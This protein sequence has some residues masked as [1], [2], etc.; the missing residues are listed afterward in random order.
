MKEN[1]KYRILWVAIGLLLVLNIGL[2]VWVSFFSKGSP[3]QPKRFFL[4]KELKFDKKQSETYRILQQEHSQQ[5]RALREDVK[6]M[7][8]A[9]YNEIS[10]PNISDEALKVKALAIESKMIDADVLTFRH[11]QQVR[12]MCTSAQQT[13]F[14]EVIIELIRSLERQG[15]RPHPREGHPPLDRSPHPDNRPPPF[16]R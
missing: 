2:L 4:E 15:G 8:E 10:Q 6:S 9:F 1:N 13:R 3:S 11:F 12:Q 7:K 14:D 5:M 16:E